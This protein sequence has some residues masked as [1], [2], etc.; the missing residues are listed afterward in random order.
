MDNLDHA[1]IGQRIKML[2]KKKGLSQTEL[3]Q[4]LGKSL[5]T[6]QKYETGEIEV[7]IS[8]INQITE[9]LETSSTYLFGYESGT[10]QIKSLSDVMDFLFKLEN[11]AG[12]DFHIDVK[13][14]PRS[15][16]WSCSISFDGKSAA[17]FNADMCLFLE[18]WQQER[19]DVQSFASTLEAYKKWKD[20]TLAYYAANT[21]E[22]VE[23][24]ELDP[25]ER[26]RKR[27]EFLENAYKKT[28]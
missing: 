6:V 21:V 16:E 8:V 1:A 4:M 13:K 22:T 27:N 24:Q 14:P 18:Q 15:K 19:E 25:D 7:S 9:I 23:P 5:R 10:T 12:I 17:E 26:I 11:V 2:R 28:E 3:A 20:T